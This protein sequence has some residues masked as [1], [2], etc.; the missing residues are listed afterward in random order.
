MSELKSV[1][2]RSRAT[3]IEDALGAITLFGLLAVG[4]HIAF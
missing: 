3:M 2:I 4:L 1:L